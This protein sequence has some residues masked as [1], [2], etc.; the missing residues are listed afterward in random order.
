MSLPAP[1]P[2]LIYDGDCGFCTHTITWLYRHAR[3][4]APATPTGPST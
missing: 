4:T 3:P 1:A 2:L